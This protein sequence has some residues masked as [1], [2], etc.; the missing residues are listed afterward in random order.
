MMKKRNKTI[1][2]ILAVISSLCVVCLLA[3]LA[4][5]NTDTRPRHIQFAEEY[6]GSPDVYF[7]IFNS[8]DCDFLQEKFDTAYAANQAAEAGTI[9]SKRS[10]GFMTATDE[11]MREIGCYETKQMPIEQVIANTAAAAQTQTMIVAPP[12]STPFVYNT[13]TMLPPVTLAP[14][15]TPI[16]TDTPFLLLATQPSTSGGAVCSCAGD[17]LNCSNFQTRASA[18]ACFNYCITQ[19]AGNI[20]KLDQ[21]NDGNACESLP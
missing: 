7:E 14:S 4:I 12:S 20:H 11:R 2:Y 19:G 21:D 10:I 5:N 18:Q 8:T 6:D 13:P 17:T 16:P 9:Y 15:F 3:M 1:F